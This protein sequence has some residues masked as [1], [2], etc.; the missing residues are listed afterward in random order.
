MHRI[1]CPW[2]GPRDEAEFAYRGDATVRRPAPD[3]WA[4]AGWGA[5]PSPYGPYFHWRSTWSRPA[6]VHVRIP[7]T[8][9]RVVRIGAKGKVRSVKVRRLLRS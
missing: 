9:E 7:V 1:D 4:Y 5:L 3:P 8:E 2:C 6:W